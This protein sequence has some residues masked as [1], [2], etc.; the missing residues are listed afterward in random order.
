[1]P[2]S[3]AVNAHVARARRLGCV[4]EIVPCSPSEIA[5]SFSPQATAAVIS[6]VIAGG[7]W[8]VGRR[9]S[10]DGVRIVGT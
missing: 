6:A 4:A 3:K 7:R 8:R 9:I 1:M 5:G 10:P 2:E